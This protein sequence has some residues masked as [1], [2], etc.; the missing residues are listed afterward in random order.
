MRGQSSVVSRQWSVV[1]LIVALCIVFGSQFTIHAQSCMDSV[2][3]V[4]KAKIVSVQKPCWDNIADEYNRRG[5]QIETQD[6]L[7][8]S[9]KKDTSILRKKVYNYKRFALEK[10]LIADSLAQAYHNC[11]EK[12]QKQIVWTA[13]LDNSL[14]KSKR[15]RKW[16][17]ALGFGSATVLYGLLYYIFKTTE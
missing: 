11:S 12:Y 4:P 7:I 14:Q 10:G 6:K 5:D 16:Y 9:L 2:A 3:I 17:V 13:Q 8:N 15:N 1:R